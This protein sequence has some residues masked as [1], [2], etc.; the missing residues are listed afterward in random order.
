MEQKNNNVKAALILGIFILVSAIILAYSN[1]YANDGMIIVD[2]WKHE[3][4]KPK[5]R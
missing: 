5:V 2:K 4:I 3:L 1:R